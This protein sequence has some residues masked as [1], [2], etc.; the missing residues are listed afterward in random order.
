[1]GGPPWPPAVSPVKTL[2]NLNIPHNGLLSSIRPYSALSHKP[3]S[4]IIAPKV[5]IYET[6]GLLGYMAGT[7]VMAE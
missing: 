2:R 3:N 7:V 5:V 4:C 1:M 6:K